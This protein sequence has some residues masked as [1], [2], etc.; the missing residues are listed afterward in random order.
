MLL[1]LNNLWDL[2]DLPFWSDK[3][4]DSVCHK[5]HHWISKSSGST[6]RK[7]YHQFT[8]TDSKE[9]TKNER[10]TSQHWLSDD[11]K[12]HH[13]PSKTT[14]TTRRKPYWWIE[15][16]KNVSV[17]VYQ[18]PQHGFLT[19]TTYNTKFSSVCLGPQNNYLE[20]WVW[21]ALVGSSIIYLQKNF[22]P[23]NS[24]HIVHKELKRIRNKGLGS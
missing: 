15:K 2:S 21:T 8:L 6:T 10:E 13:W 9:K 23:K 20:V 14:S 18:M 12:T 24:I 22:S 4:I 3:S 19:D 1:L 7:P 5:T 16:N 11:H 17:R